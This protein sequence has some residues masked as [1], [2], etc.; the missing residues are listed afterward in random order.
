MIDKL[1]SPSNRT[2][3]SRFKD[4]VK[5]LGSH[6]NWDDF[7]RVMVNLT[8]L[9]INLPGETRPE[10]LHL[11]GFRPKLDKLSLEAEQRGVEIA[12]AGFVDSQRKTLIF[13]KTTAGNSHSVT[14]NVDP[15]PGRERFQAPVLSMHVHPESPGFSGQDF[16][17]LLG[18][19]SMK[20]MF[21]LLGNTDF[22]VM[23]TTFTPDLLSVD[24]I[25]HRLNHLLKECRLD[26]SGETGGL[27]SFLIKLVRFNKLVCLEYG[28]TMY[29]AGKSDKDLAKR[30][31][32][33]HF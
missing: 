18:S 15:E 4:S 1:Y 6:W 16:L 19:S 12:R 7:K 13:G 31:D 27:G 33:T 14:L 30:V 5:A 10:S 20:S 32:V 21:M 3:E 29:V 28:L 22:I 17:H 8:L 9:N 23:K 24:D 26:S 11:Q 25:N 2:A